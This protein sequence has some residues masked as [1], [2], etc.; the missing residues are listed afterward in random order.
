MILTGKA[1]QDFEKW[2]RE[3]KV[4]PY[5]HA[6]NRIDVWG[7]ENITESFL[8]PLIKEWFDSV[9]IYIDTYSWGENFPI[10]FGGEIIEYKIG[11]VKTVDGLKTRNEAL[12]AAITNANTIYNDKHTN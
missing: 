10:T 12:K 11:I 8:I 2:L 9:G 1:K 4:Y 7:I 5:S 6:G 3:N